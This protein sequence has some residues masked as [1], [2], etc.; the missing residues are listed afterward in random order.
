MSRSSIW[1]VSSHGPPIRTFREALIPNFNH[2]LSHMSFT[3]ELALLVCEQLWSTYQNLPR[4]SH[5]AKRQYH[6]QKLAFQLEPFEIRL[7]NGPK[8]P[9]VI[10][11]NVQ[12]PN[13]SSS[14]SKLL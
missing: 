1:F 9:H 13:T 3:T 4:S 12:N 8:S 11:V 5:T 10:R 2:T 14:P 7:A 6:N